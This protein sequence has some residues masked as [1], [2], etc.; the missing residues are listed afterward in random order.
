MIVTTFGEDLD[1]IEVVRLHD[2]IE[3]IATRT[4]IPLA[5]LSTVNQLSFVWRLYTKHRRDTRAF[6]SCV[7]F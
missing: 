5:N 1:T 4:N 3:A 7:P 6:L 2:N